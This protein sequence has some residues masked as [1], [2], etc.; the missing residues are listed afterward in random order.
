MEEERQEEE[1]ERIA[2][3]TLLSAIQTKVGEQSGGHMYVEIEV[4]GK[5]L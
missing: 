1:E 3:T 4:S 2:L 5:K